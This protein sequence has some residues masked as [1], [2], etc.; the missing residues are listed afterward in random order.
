[1]TWIFVVID[2]VSVRIMILD[3]IVLLLANVLVPKSPGQLIWPVG[4]N[5]SPM[6][7]CWFLQ[8]K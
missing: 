5:N 3:S 4:T 2:D 1:M 8:A 6:V 7:N